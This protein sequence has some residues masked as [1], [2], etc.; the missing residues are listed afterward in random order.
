MK[1]QSAIGLWA[2]A[3]LGLVGCDGKSS[4]SGTASASASGAAASGAAAQRLTCEARV[5]GGRGIH[6]AKAVAQPGDSEAAVKKR[7]RGDA[8]K[9]MCQAETKRKAKPS[10]TGSPSASSSAVASA[11]ASAAASASAEQRP[12]A[13]A[14]A[15]DPL[16]GCVARCE[17]DIQAGKVGLRTICQGPKP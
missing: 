5:T 13:S 9:L 14:A 10:A 4:S 7:A 2:A 16:R 8:C 15:G 1:R 3:V 17:V 12:A 11:S 6:S